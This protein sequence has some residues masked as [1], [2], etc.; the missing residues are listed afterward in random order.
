MLSPKPCSTIIR[1]GCFFR[2]RGDEFGVKHVSISCWRGKGLGASLKPR[3]LA[4]F[5][6]GRSQ[7][8]GASPAACSNSLWLRRKDRAA[9]RFAR[10]V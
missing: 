4:W 10:R 8:G 6:A 5:C 1:R 9:R 2:L 3:Y 7:F